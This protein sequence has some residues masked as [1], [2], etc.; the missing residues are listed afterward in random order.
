MRAALCQ[1][2]AQRGDAVVV[3]EIRPQVEHLQVGV[4]LQ[5]L[6]DR[7]RALVLD[8]IAAQPVDPTIADVRN[9][10]TWSYRCYH[11]NRR[12]H[13]SEFRIFARPS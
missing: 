12:T 11:T 7:R 10:G 8:V 9:K 3:D 5:R 6:G 4:V 1:R 13:I 2:L